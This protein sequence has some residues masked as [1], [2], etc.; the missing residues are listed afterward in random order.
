MADATANPFPMFERAQCAEHRARL[1]SLEHGFES[2]DKK[3]DKLLF[4]IVGTLCAALGG[5]VLQVLF[6][7]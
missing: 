6:R 7:R 4:G 2:L 1:T 5:L 3:I